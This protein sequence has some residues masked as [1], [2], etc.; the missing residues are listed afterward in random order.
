MD[1]LSNVILVILQL[2]SRRERVKESLNRSFDLAN[3]VSRARAIAI[4]PA[5]EKLLEYADF[6]GQSCTACASAAGVKLLGSAAR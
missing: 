4:T 5:F 2:T 6:D 1:L 3:T